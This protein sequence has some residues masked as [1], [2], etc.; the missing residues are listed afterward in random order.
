M[1]G[2]LDFAKR[3]KNLIAEFL[4]DKLKLT[5]SLEKTKITHMAKDRANFLGFR[6]W[7]PRRPIGKVNKIFNPRA[8][9]RIDARISQSNV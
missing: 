4:A 5:L 3:I 8:N 2:S 1:I 7:V 9:R 6:F